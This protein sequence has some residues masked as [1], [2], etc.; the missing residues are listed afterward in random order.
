MMHDN[1]QLRVEATVEKAVRDRMNSILSRYAEKTED[2]KDKEIKTLTGMV[3][4][5]N[6][7]ANE[8]KSNYAELK[9]KVEELE[10]KM[11]KKKA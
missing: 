1:L 11:G 4:T 6:E 3:L 9:E 2:E 8:Y 5:A 10:R 7:E